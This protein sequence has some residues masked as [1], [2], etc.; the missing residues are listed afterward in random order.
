M[1]DEKSAELINEKNENLIGVLLALF[2][3]VSGVTMLFLHKSKFTILNESTSEFA[4]HNDESHLQR[5]IESYDECISD[6][7]NG[8]LSVRQSCSSDL[9]SAILRNEWVTRAVFEALLKINRLDI[10]ERMGYFDPSNELAQNHTWHDLLNKYEGNH[11]AAVKMKAIVMIKG[12]RYKSAYN[13]ITSVFASAN[14]DNKHVVATIVRGILK[15]F[16]CIPDMAVWAPYS[17]DDVTYGYKRPV[18]NSDY[19]S[20]PIPG[21]IL[22][23]LRVELDKGVIPELRDSC[24]LKAFKL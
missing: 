3:V 6:Y 10:A 8:F 22:S 2:I 11:F 24:D 20:S 17:I 9:R 14:M 16:G 13:S 18:M 12:G 7:D 5:F 15:E 4:A 23:K 1:N 21:D 19:T